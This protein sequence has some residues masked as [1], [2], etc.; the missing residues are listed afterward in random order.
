MP[1][2]CTESQTGRAPSFSAWVAAA[3]F[4]VL[5]VVRDDPLTWVVLA[6]MVAM[7]VFALPNLRA[8]RHDVFERVHRFAGWTA[9]DGQVISLVRSPRLIARLAA[10]EMHPLDTND[11]RLLL[12]EQLG[13]GFCNITKCCSEVCP[14]GI[15]LTDNGIIPLKERVV[16]RKFDP[17]TWLGSKIGRRPRP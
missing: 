12:K 4:A 2:S 16:D 1:M 10:L 8:R 14:E 9:T 11:R 5:A 17:L 13:L 6:L 3:W 15:H 7:V